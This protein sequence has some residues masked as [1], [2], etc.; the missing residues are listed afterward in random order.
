MRKRN[1]NENLTS[2]RT[3]PPHLLS[4]Q[5]SHPQRPP[6]HL[7]PSA[8][9]IRPSASS[10]RP[11]ASST[12]VAPTPAL[13]IHPPPRPASRLC[14][15][16]STVEESLWGHMP[17]HI[18]KENAH[19]PPIVGLRNVAESLLRARHRRY[20]NSVPALHIAHAREGCR[21][22]TS[23]VPYLQPYLFSLKLD[24]LCKE[25]RVSVHA[26]RRGGAERLWWAPRSKCGSTPRALLF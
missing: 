19:R 11:S 21:H 16:A 22:L 9:S 15:P 20:S 13:H 26:Q 7:G 8:S 24:C 17:A 18:D 2:P 3:R 1:E 23:C 4:P 5:A 14:P 12:R 25:A 10:I 6:T